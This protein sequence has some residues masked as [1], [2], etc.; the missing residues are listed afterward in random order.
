MTK[1]SLTV[2]QSLLN[3]AIV[4]SAK[5]TRVEFNGLRFYSKKQPLIEELKV[6]TERK[7]RLPEIEFFFETDLS[8]RR[9]SQRL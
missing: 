1:K 6:K 9:L 7:T 2:E 5:F 3:N 8:E 4:A